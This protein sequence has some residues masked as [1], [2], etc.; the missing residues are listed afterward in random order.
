MTT[1]RNFAR[2]A[3]AATAALTTAL[4]AQAVNGGVGLDLR[5]QR[6]E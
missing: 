6:V 5:R 4:P 1:R 2:L 3:L